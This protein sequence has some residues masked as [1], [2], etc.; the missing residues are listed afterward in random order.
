M[1]RPSG[2]TRTDFRDESWPDEGGQRWQRWSRW[3][4]WS[5]R[6]RER[7]RDRERERER[8][9]KKE[10]RERGGRKLMPVETFHQ[11]CQLV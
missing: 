8:R 6:A 9:K 4:R 11:S 2:T 7:E 10:R 1:E 5:T 3:W